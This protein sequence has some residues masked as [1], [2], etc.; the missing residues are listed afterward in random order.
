MSKEFEFR[1]T[2]EATDQ[3]KQEILLMAKSY[4][5]AIQKAE[6]ENPRR[7]CV[8]VKYTD[9]EISKFDHQLQIAIERM[10]QEDSLV[11]NVV[12]MAYDDQGHLNSHRMEY[13][14]AEELALVMEKFHEYELII[15]DGGNNVGDRWFRTFYPQQLRTTFVD[16][17]G[18]SEKGA[19]DQQLICSH[20]EKPSMEAYKQAV[21]KWYRYEGTSDLIMDMFKSAFPY[22][23]KEDEDSEEEFLLSLVEQ[24]H[25]GS[26]N[27]CDLTFAN[28]RIGPL[29]P[30]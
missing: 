28:Y 8:S 23:E 1:V 25:D 29:V 26:Q 3:T 5:D 11:G 30:L 15:F 7:K 27:G 19:S 20:D 2:T 17:N 4:Q 14:D 12:I 9:K 6:K 18:I 13:E 10:T 21:L 16:R 24:D 22:S